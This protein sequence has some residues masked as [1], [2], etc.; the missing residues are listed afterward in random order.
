M[1]EQS[2]EPNIAEEEVELETLVHDLS[3]QLHAKR[4]SVQ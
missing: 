3:G 1:L 4:A 2:V